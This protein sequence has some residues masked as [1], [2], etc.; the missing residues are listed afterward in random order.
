LRLPLSNVASYFE[1]PAPG[2]TKLEKNA[3]RECPGFVQ[4]AVDRLAK[5]KAPTT[6]LN[7]QQALI[8][9]QVAQMTACVQ[10]IAA[11]GGGWDKSQL[12][13]LTQVTQKP[14]K[15]ESSIQH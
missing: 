14:A 5:C 10:L 7:N 2:G 15:A 6:L 3:I 9:S 12:P 8:N 4:I 11:L 13:N 1:I